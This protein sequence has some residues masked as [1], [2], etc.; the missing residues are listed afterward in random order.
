MNTQ[1]TPQ[2]QD[3]GRIG[4]RQQDVLDRLATAHQQ[5]KEATDPQAKV[6]TARTVANLA[7]GY[8]WL[9]V[10]EARRQGHHGLENLLRGME[11]D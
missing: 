9:A 10:T 2:G 4:D 5:L 7:E 8:G 3:R 1:R 6:E 11:S